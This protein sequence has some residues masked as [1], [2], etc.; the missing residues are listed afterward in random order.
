MNYN[1]LT[2]KQI[3]PTITK[4][5]K[6]ELVSMMK[7]QPAKY[8][9]DTLTQQSLITPYTTT[10]INSTSMSD[11]TDGF[12]MN[13]DP[14]FL[15]RV[16]NTF[17]VS[18]KL[19]FK[20]GRAAHVARTLLHE[21]DILEAREKNANNAKKGKEVKELLANHKKLTAMLN[22]RAFGCKIGEDSLKACLKMTEKKSQDE[23]RIIQKKE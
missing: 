19:N 4:G 13:Y 12:E 23:A 21:S 16:P 17:T 1:L 6:A 18:T 11:L 3:L 5:E 15:N 22:F 8:F 14:H 20:S 10:I 2:A 9:A 7:V